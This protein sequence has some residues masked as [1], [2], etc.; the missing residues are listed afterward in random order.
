MDRITPPQPATIIPATTFTLPQWE[1]LLA[2]RK[3]YWRERDLFDARE[4][5]HLRFLRWLYRTGRLVP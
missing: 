4:R 1:D 3:R 2:L 5:A